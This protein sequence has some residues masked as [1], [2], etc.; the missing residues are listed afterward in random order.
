M[1]QDP[2]DIERWVNRTGGICGPGDMG[3]WGE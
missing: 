3:K 2:R 1:S